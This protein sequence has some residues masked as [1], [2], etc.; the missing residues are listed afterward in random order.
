[1]NIPNS[2][3]VIRAVKS[4]YHIKRG[5]LTWKAFQPPK[6]RSVI[7]VIR[8]AKGNHFCKNQAREIGETHYVGVASLLC[9]KLRDGG[10]LV[11]DQRIGSYEGHAEIDVGVRTPL[12]DEPSDPETNHRLRT[13]CQQLL[14]MACYLKDHEPESDK[15]NGPDMCSWADESEQ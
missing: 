5:Q 1:M 15:W 14:S 7:S 9:G 3:C 11:C 8:H 4:S 12:E 6:G 2:E 13:Q 10:F